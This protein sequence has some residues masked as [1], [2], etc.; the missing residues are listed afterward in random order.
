MGRVIKMAERISAIQVEVWNSEKGRW[1]W[2]SVEYANI[3]AEVKDAGWEFA[4]LDNDGTVAMTRN[5]YVNRFRNTPV[6]F[7]KKEASKD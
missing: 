3:W 5:G 7:K 4:Y 1:E 6:V 2:K